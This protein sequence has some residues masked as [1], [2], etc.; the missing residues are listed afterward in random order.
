M[1][2]LACPA[3]GNVPPFTLRGECLICN[4]LESNFTLMSE[5]ER[6]V[7]AKRYDSIHKA[8][9]TDITKEE[10]QETLKD[11]FG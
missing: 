4:G 10:I 2:I 3:C 11:L 5:S 8:S 7:I 9:S 6:S 1:K